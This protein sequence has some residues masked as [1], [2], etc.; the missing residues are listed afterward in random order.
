MRGRAIGRGRLVRRRNKRGTVYVGDWSDA[1][2]K[3]RRQV[4]STDRRV[5]ERQLGDII[6][7]R[8]LELAG[9]GREESHDRL[10]EEVRGLYESDLEQ[11]VSAGHLS[12]L[13]GRLKRVLGGLRA[14]RVSELQTSDLLEW[15]RRRIEDGASNRTANLDVAAVQGMLRWAVDC[16]VIASNPLAKLKRLPQGQKHQRYRRRALTE[17]E[18]ERFLTAAIEDDAEQARHVAA[19][20]TI[21]NGT[22]GSR[23]AGRERSHRVPQYPLWLALVETGARWGALSQTVWQDLDEE[24]ATLRLRAETAKSGREQTNPIRKEL[25]QELVALRELQTELLGDV[26]GDGDRIFL[27]P[28]GEP[29]GK[30]SR[31]AMRIFDRLLDRAELEK[32]DASGQKLD[33]HALRHTYG[34]RLLRA[35]VGLHQ[36]QKLM[37]HSSPELTARVYAHL[38]CDDLRDAVERLPRGGGGGSRSQLRGLPGTKL[39][40]G[41]GSFG[42]VARKSLEGMERVIGIEP[43]TF[44]LGS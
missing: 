18:I 44:S 38:V 14:R 8:D 20:R 40:H 21:K 25:V 2:G 36:V 32:I 6:R 34:T 39:A 33:I 3:R 29:W 11:R 23:Y 26:P 10:L 31:N 17:A 15:R 24:S 5:A 19:E 42:R 35:G 9:L 4:L 7:R 43:T 28:R 41:K 30:Q 27:T 13:K 37:G 22:K 12:N 16:D 1:S